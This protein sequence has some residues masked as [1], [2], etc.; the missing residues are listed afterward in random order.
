MNW[1]SA[2]N[3]DFMYMYFTLWL[4]STLGT[5]YDWNKMNKKEKAKLRKLADNFKWPEE[6]HCPECGRKHE[7]ADK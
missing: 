2:T 5:K 6:E 1:D 4:N 3:K 7:E